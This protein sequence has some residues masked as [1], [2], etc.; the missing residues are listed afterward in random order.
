MNCCFHLQ[1]KKKTHT[2]TQKQKNQNLQQFLVQKYI[3]LDEK[4]VRQYYV[5]YITMNS[6]NNPRYQ[7][8][9]LAQLEAFLTI[10]QSKRETTNQLKSHLGVPRRFE[11]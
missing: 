1:P 5:V 8:A 4:C 2:H 11:L 9:S 6:K 3:F 7:E 10:T